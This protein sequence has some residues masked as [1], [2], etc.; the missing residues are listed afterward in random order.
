[1]ENPG[2]VLKASVDGPYGT[3]PD[4]TLYSRVLFIAGGS[5]ASFTCGT[6]VDLLRRLGESTST[7]IEFV[8]VLKEQGKSRNLDA[9]LKLT[10]DRTNRMVCEGTRRAYFLTLCECP[11]L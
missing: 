1:M 2:Q 10:L 7:A 5:G 3:I 8:W 11:Y 9:D 4:F 6:A